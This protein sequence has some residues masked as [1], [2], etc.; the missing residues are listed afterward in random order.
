MTAAVNIQNCIAKG[1]SYGS[2]WRGI[3]VKM[4]LGVV[5]KYRLE[6]KAGAGSDERLGDNGHVPDCRTLNVSL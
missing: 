6:P 5:Q 1:G 2:L 4:A 3:E